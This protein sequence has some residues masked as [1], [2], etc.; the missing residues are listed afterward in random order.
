MRTVAADRCVAMRYG[1]AGEESMRTRTRALNDSMAGQDA[2]AAFRHVRVRVAR[3]TQHGLQ[4]DWLDRVLS[5]VWGTTP[6]RTV[7]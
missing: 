5:L 2:G 4:I 3:C 6:A 7:Q 1:D